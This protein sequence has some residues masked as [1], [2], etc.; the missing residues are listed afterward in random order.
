[1]KRRE[2]RNTEL[3]TENEQLVCKINLWPRE[4]ESWGFVAA[5]TNMVLGEVVVSVAIVTLYVD[6]LGEGMKTRF[7][8]RQM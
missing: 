1:M 8:F 3:P 5:P 2:I 4:I 7:V 6:I